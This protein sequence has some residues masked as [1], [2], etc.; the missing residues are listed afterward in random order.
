MKQHRHWENH[1]NNVIA[2]KL[3]WSELEFD[4]KYAVAKRAKL[5]GIKGEQLKNFAFT[6]SDMDWLLRTI[7]TA[8]GNVKNKLKSALVDHSH[9][10]SDELLKHPCEYNLIFRF[11]DEWLG[12]ADTLMNLIH[13]YIVDYCTAEY[14][15]MIPE[16]NT[17][18]IKENCE[19]ILL[20]AYDEINA[21][22]LT[23]IPR[24]RL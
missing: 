10:A 20:K 19:A 12:N 17:D 3:L 8:I 2:V 14:L 9:M 7:D 4:V 23:D 5:A 16:V 6:P 15:D 21:I 1:D 18:K 24:F 22:D 11:D 13:S